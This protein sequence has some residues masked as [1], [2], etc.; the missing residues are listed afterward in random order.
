MG[1]MTLEELQAKHP[2]ADQAAYDQAREAAV[3]AGKMAELVYAMRTHASLTQAELGRRI[4]TTQ[5]SI[6]RMESGGSLLTIEMIARLAQAT[7]VPVRIQVPGV[8]DV[9]V[10]AGQ[11]RSTRARRAGQRKARRRADVLAD[12]ES[13]A[14]AERLAAEKD[15]KRA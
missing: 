4:G 7:G 11:S 8:A 15:R 14:E 9:E 12:V 3:L 10:L 1:R 13:H 2:P 5:S 6:A